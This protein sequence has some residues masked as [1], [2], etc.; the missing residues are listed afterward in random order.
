[1]P[2]QAESDPAVPDGVAS[3]VGPKDGSLERGTRSPSDIRRLSDA[4]KLDVLAA[5]VGARATR[6][7][8]PCADED[9]ARGALDR[10]FA[11]LH[12]LESSGKG[13]VRILQLGD[14]HTAADYITRKAREYLQAR[15]GDAGRGFVHV[16]QRVE[17]GG[18]RRGRSGPWQRMRIVDPSGGLQALGFSGI[19]FESYGKDARLEYS[20]DEDDVR[21]ALFYYAVPRGGKAILSYDGR[22]LGEID[23]D[24]G[25]SESRMRAFDLAT[26]RVAPPAPNRG[27][28]FPKALTITATGPK[29]RIFGLS[30]ESGDPGLLYD[31]IGPVG[32]DARAYLSL[33]PS[34]RAESLS[35]LAPDLIILMV[36]GNDA[37]MVQ[38]GTRTIDQVRTDLEQ[39][40]AA[41][42]GDRPEADCM[43]WSP[44][45]AGRLQAGEISSKEFIGEVR[46]VQRL[47]A[48]KFGCG[49]WDMYRS[50]GGTG[51][52]SRWHKA[53]I[54]NDDLV[55]PRAAGG[56]LVGHLFATSFLR[57]FDEST[58][59]N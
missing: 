40:I 13:H 12:A 11:R 30:F 57:A 1:M 34:S 7:D 24:A 55:H 47:V 2:D 44:M 39:L 49:F 33:D 16:D 14:S 59:P 48:R 42:K 3:G 23:V 20:V 50:M 28:E 4:G 51:S 45:D 17:Y 27:A 37:R 6:I 56:D 19:A 31:S 38:G 32:A 43:L 52:F 58:R 5:R 9:C 41:L 36:G 18:R 29:V 35:A 46:D 53:G 26:G 22:D 25:L 10:V 21:V 54:M 15:F 8:T